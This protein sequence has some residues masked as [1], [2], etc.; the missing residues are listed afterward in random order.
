MVECEVCGFEAKNNRGL[1]THQ[2]S[3]HPELFDETTEEKEDEERIE[4]VLQEDNPDSENLENSVSENK[5][6]TEKSSNNSELDQSQSQV[7]PDSE[8]GSEGGSEGTI[9]YG[10]IRYCKHHGPV[11]PKQI[12]EGVKKWSVPCATPSW[13]RTPTLDKL[14]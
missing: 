5:S 9:H 11:P 6:G 1:A 7:Y 4:E 8:N 3:Q 2:R 12:D 14:K 13:P 10:E